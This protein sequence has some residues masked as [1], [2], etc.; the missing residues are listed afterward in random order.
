MKFTDISEGST[1]FPPIETSDF[2]AP[3]HTNMDNTDSSDNECQVIHVV[4]FVERC[5]CYVNIVCKSFLF[6]SEDHFLDLRGDEIK[7]P[8]TLPVF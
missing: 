4:S 3:S 2:T 5:S 1:Y 7:F 6:V 8:Q